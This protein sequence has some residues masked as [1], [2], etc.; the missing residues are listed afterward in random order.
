MAGGI[1]PA[2]PQPSLPEA[3]SPVRQVSF[4]A[5]GSPEQRVRAQIRPDQDLGK[6]R[7]R[8]F[9]VRRENPVVGTGGE[10]APER[11]P[12]H[13][14]CLHL[15]TSR[16]FAASLVSIYGDNNYYYYVML[17]SN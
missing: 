4:P 14:V 12:G 6:V 5:D 7:V 8:D 16:N 10:V 15:F 3:Q 11:R 9:P 13:I 2:P 1:A 17:E